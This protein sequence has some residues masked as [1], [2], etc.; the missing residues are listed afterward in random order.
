VIALLVVLVGVGAFAWG[1]ARVSEVPPPAP[2]ASRAER[3]YVGLSATC[4][5]TDGRGSWRATFFL[6]RPGDLTDPA[7]MRQHTDEYL[8]EMIKHGGAPFG[9]PGMPAFGASVKDEDIR[10]L[11]EYLRSL[12]G[13]AA[14]AGG[15]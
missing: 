10:A 15:R 8:V 7:R 6:I 4:H 9:R 3:I 5:G 1:V 13:G 11:V 2:G 12:S 14:R